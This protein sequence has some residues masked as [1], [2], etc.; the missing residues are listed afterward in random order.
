[1]KN[2]LRPGCVAL[3]VCVGWLLCAAFAARISQAQSAQGTWQFTVS[4]DSRNCGDVVMPAIAA[5]VR[6]RNAK[7]YWHLGDFRAIYTFDEDILHQNDRL[8]QPL[9]IYAYEN[10]A[11]QDFIEH[12]MTPFGDLPVFLGLGNHET[13][14]P[15]NREQVLLQFAD[16]FGS[17]VIREQ[18]LKD[19]PRDHA[20][21]A[22][23]H[24][25]EG[26]VDFITLDN[27]TTDQF[28]GAQL[29]WFDNLLK[30]DMADASVSSI[31]LG[32][33][34]ALPD[35]I[36]AGH[37]M[38]TSPVGTESGRHVYQQLVQAQIRGHKHIYILA[39]HSHFYM[40]NIFNTDFISSHGGV[41]PGWIVGTAGAVRYPLPPDSKNAIGAQTNVYG[42]LLATVHPD[43]LIN[44]DFQKIEESHVPSDVVS[45]YQTG[46]VHWCFAEN[47]Q[48]R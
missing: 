1:M 29:F 13:I 21:R 39:S 4:G 35:S 15:K 46:F 31:V 12:Q 30:R 38:N 26:N 18:R 43:G 37:S 2:G 3:A 8:A 40:G 33:H 32:M 27:A 6:R 20:L 47:T 25:R 45:R 22:Y 28:D 34:E 16:W 7:F 17:P 36:S 48:A 24:W 23:Y 10:M 44:F 14:L 19:D 11:W 5:E 9:S 42:Y 41:L